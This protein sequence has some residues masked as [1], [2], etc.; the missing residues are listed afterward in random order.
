MQS[1]LNEYNVEAVK[2]KHLEMEY[3]KLIDKFGS[4]KVN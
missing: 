2:W 1:L 3:F 4:T